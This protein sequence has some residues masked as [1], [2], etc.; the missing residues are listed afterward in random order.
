VRKAR[1]IFEFSGRN[2]MEAYEHG[3]SA[4]LLQ[5]RETTVGW[6]ARKTFDAPVV[7][8]FFLD[9]PIL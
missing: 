1:L 8:S 2:Q 4:K 6:I 7:W 3:Q 5:G 9:I